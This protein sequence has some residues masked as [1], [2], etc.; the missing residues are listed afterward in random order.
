VLKSLIIPNPALLSVVPL[1]KE[2][3]Y[4]PAV[5][6]IGATLQKKRPSRSAKYGSVI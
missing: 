3:M 6:V 1:I 5:T 4:L 2:P